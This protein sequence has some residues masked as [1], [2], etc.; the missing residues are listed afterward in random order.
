MAVLKKLKHRIV[1]PI[2]NPIYIWRLR[3]TKCRHT[4]SRRQAVCLFDAKVI[5][6]LVDALAWACQ[7]E[8]T[9]AIQIDD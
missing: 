6:S 2:T 3:N 5:R 9:D 4:R 8:E 1:K 7:S